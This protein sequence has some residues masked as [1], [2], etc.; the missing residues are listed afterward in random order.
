MRGLGKSLPFIKVLAGVYIAAGC[1]GV[2]NT[3]VVKLETVCL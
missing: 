3:V 2:R 1:L